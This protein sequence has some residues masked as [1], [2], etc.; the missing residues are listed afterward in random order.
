MLLFVAIETAPIFTKLIS[1]RSPYDYLLTEKEHVYEMETKQSTTQRSNEV[2]HALMI[3]T[4]VG[5][6]QAKSEIK[7][8]KAEIDAEL[9]ERLS[10][11]ERRILGM[12]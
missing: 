4:E 6:H 3:N 5:F 10:N 8:R 2:K 1:P 12:G 11:A 7:G 9:R